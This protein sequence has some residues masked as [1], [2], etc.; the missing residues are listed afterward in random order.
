VPEADRQRSRTKARAYWLLAL[1]ELEQPS[2]RPCLLLVGGLPGSGKSTL[3]RELAVSAGFQVIRSDVVRKELAGVSGPARS[4]RALDEGIYS[5]EWTERTYAECLKRAEAMLFE[6]RRVLIDASFQAQE[7]RQLFLDGAVRWGVPALFLVCRA[8]PAIV[9]Q[10]LQER[11][12]DVS[13]ADWQVYQHA[14]A[15]W[16]PAQGQ[17]VR[18][19]DTSGSVSESVEQAVRRLS[20]LGM[21]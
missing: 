9:R 19:I 18:E 8:D 17:L 2:Q 1:G 13:D 21:A 16:G 12:N 4:D 11:Q 7:K 20:E 5:A 3:A 15:R 14:A 10:R 6:G